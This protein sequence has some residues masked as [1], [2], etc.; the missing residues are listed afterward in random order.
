MLISL[1][2]VTV[3]SLVP[4]THCPVRQVLNA[5]FIELLVNF[6]L[7]QNTSQTA[8]RQRVLETNNLKNE[9]ALRQKGEKKVKTELKSCK[10]QQWLALASGKASDGFR[11]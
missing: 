10:A 8:H 5:T 6:S 4:S 11:C 9:K 7:Q 2:V 3:V 1:L